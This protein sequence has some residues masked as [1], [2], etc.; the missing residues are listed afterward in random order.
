MKD[1]QLL[2]EARALLRMDVEYMAVWTPQGWKAPKGFP[3]RELLC[4]P[5]TGGKT[6]QVKTARMVKYLEAA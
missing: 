4:I 6:W 2:A 1:P 5:S 3:R